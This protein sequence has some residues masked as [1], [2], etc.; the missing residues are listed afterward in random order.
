MKK[1]L[2]ERRSA[3]RLAPVG[4]LAEAA[5]TLCHHHNRQGDIGKQFGVFVEEL[6]QFGSMQQQAAGIGV[7]EL[8]F[9]VPGV[10]D[11]QGLRRG[12]ATGTRGR[13]GRW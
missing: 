3:S 11:R 5:M 13:G 12:A 8:V 4:A 7:G 9:Q 1:Q 6:F 2:L 10:A